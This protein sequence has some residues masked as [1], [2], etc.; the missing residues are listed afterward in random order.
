MAGGAEK[1]ERAAELLAGNDLLR[2]DFEDPGV[3][4]QETPPEVLIGEVNPPE[5]T[6]VGLP[7][8]TAAPVR[9]EPPE[10]LFGEISPPPDFPLLP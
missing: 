1:A 2:R 3:H 7:H 4:P 5:I 10:I 8:G 6:T 9:E